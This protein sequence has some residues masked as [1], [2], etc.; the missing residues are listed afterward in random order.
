MHTAPVRAQGPHPLSP[1]QVS[2]FLDCAYRW[3]CSHAL[4]LPDP[5]NGG[6]A[7]GR[8]IHSTAAAVLRLRMQGDPL[9]T[10]TATLNHF[11]QQIGQEIR[12]SQLAPDEQPEELRTRGAGMIA[13]WLE[14][15]APETGKVLGVEQEM[16]G[17]IAGVTVNA[18]ADVITEEMVTD[19]KTAAKR[20]GEISS[21]HLF[22][23][24]TYAMLASKKRARLITITKTKEP[25]IVQHTVQITDSHRKYAETIYP[26]VAEA[27]TTGVYLPRRASYLCSR[28]HC[29]FW[30]HC[31]AEHG[32]TVRD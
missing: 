21:D 4:Q 11:E 25:A 30:R 15:A 19:L 2:T 24:V 20:P 22:Q 26:A 17:Q 31:E 13:L 27:M 1:S 18:I 7:L 3:Y 6:L 5:P 9:P 12:D 10:R 32:G 16:T 8:A 28:K 29:A 23:L 14:R